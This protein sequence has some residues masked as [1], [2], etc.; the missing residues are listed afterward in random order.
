MASPPLE[1]EGV[2]RLRMQRNLFSAIA[3]AA[4][5][6]TGLALPRRVADYRELKAVHARV[7]E[8]QANIVVAQRQIREAEDQI[9]AVQQEIKRQ[10][11]Q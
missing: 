1:L 6:A 4:L 7:V 2:R 3:A 11:A 8:L 10:Q 9:L 5:A